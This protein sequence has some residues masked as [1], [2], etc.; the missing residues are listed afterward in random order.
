MAIHAFISQTAAF[1]KILEHLLPW[2]RAA[3]FAPFV[4][5][6]GAFATFLGLEPVCGFC[7]NLQILL[8]ALCIH[9]IL[10]AP[11]LWVLPLELW[12]KLVH[13]PKKVR[14][15]MKTDQAKRSDHQVIAHMHEK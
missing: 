6:R 2:S 14:Q 13:V 11:Q 1:D 4:S 15:V 3:S 9:E 7:L 5:V 12:F 8:L 10:L